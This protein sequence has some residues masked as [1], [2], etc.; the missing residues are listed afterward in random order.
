[1][2]DGITTASGITLG[3]ASRSTRLLGQCVDGFIAG[4]PVFIANLLGQPL[5]TIIAVVWAF[6]YLIF[7]DG[8]AGQSV[9]KKWLGMRVV[10]AKTGAPCT[11]G[12]SFVRNILLTFLG[13][14]D[15]IFIFGDRHQRLGDKAAGTIVVVAD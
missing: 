5:V 9:A 8:N 7:S 1:M 15:W 2:T 14:I 6:F 3:H 10:D 12:Q 13:P 11:Y 4:A